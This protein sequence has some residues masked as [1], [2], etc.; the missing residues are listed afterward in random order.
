[1]SLD[2]LRNKIDA[3]DEEI[4]KLLNKR[5]GF[6]EEVAKHKIGSG[7]TV[8]NALRE[9]QILDDIDKHSTH[10]S[11]ELKAVMQSIMCVSRECQYEL[12]MQEDNDWTLGKLIENA[13]KEDSN[14][15]KVAYAG[16]NGPHGELAAKQ[17][18]EN[19]KSYKGYQSFDGACRAVVDNLAD[20]AVLPLENTTTGTVNE[21]Y[22]LIPSYGLFIIASSSNAINHSL[23]S[24]KGTD[25]TDI[26]TVISHPQA[27]S[28]CSILIKKMGLVALERENTAFAAE[29]VALK[30]DKSIVALGSVTNAEIYGLDILQAI[31]NNEESNQTRFVVLSKKLSITKSANKVSLALKLPHRAGALAWVLFIFA[32]LSLNLT[33]IQS[34]PIPNIP[35]EY[36]FYVDFLCNN[37][38]SVLQALYQ[39]EKELPEIILLGWYEEKN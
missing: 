2:E 26:K 25:F 39:L 35:W 37:Q 10:Y 23:L 36:I 32:N 13:K 14:I 3:V 27:L 7:Q 9:Q 18:F 29:E 31:A 17:L 34:R 15:K 6:S 33:K 22:D 16:K 4:L 5:M 30:N 12:M 28:Q 19:A 1:M 11:R 24:V 21:V 38:K 8:Y 20:V